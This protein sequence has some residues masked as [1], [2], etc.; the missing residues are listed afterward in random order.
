MPGT[1]HDH[2][3]DC[4]PSKTTTEPNMSIHRVQSPTITATSVT[5]NSEPVEITT[6]KMASQFEVGSPLFY[7]VVGGGSG[8][9]AVLLLCL[10]CVCAILIFRRTQIKGKTVVHE[11]LAV[12]A[13][14]YR[15]ICYC[16]PILS[17]HQ[18]QCRQLRATQW[19][20]GS[21]PPASNSWTHQMRKV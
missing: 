10:L 15:D 12:L 20:G 19:N 2:S 6:D 13:I 7:A 11:P 14:S 3:T 8:I 9:V 17:V 1:L 21:Q 4:P 5:E 18:K 16:I